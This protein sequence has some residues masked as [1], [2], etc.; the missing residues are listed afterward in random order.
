MSSG[1]EQ[2]IVSDQEVEAELEVSTEEAGVSE[3]CLS[4]STQA[5]SSKTPAEI[6]DST[7]RKRQKSAARAEGNVQTKKRGRRSNVDMTIGKIGRAHV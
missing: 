1:E 5:C 6:A 2:R 4:A 3:A 7:P